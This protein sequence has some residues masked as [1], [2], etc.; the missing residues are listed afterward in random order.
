MEA[1]SSIRH[2]LKDGARRTVLAPIGKMLGAPKI[3]LSSPLTRGG[4]YL[5]YWLWAYA[6][7]TPRHP[8]RVL[9]HDVIDEWLVEFP[10]VGHLSIK[11][12]DASTLW[13][14]WVGNHEHTFG[15]SFQQHELDSFCR[16]LVASSPKFQARL[17]RARTWVKPETVVVNVRRGDYYT[18]PH[19]TAMYGIDIEGNA[20]R[21]LQ[22]LKELRRSAQ[23]VLIV[24][25]DVEWCIE[26][27]GQ[28]LPSPARVIPDRTSMFDDL[29]VLAAA[30]T[31][32]LANSTFSFWGSYLGSSLQSNHVAIAPDYHYLG[33]NGVKMREPY[34][35]RWLIAEA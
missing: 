20:T 12:D 25:D 14:D 18:Y 5:Y 2:R 26:H 16:A 22:I 23:D 6:R 4:N 35:P 3:H 24:S 34:D 27:L 11:R 1:T 7:D 28:I 29:A 30:H 15:V 19:L 33:V 21:A 32:V 8:A 13:S 9:Y 17:E 10:L 31:V